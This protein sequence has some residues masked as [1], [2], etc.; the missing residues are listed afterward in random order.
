[1]SLKVYMYTRADG[2][3]NPYHRSASR[4]LEYVYNDFSI[5]LIARGLGRQDLYDQYTK[6]SGDWVNL[7]NPNVT[8][9]GFS[10]FIQPRNANGSW[11]IN[12]AFDIGGV[13]N[14]TH[15]SPV[16]GHDDCFLVRLFSLHR[17]LRRLCCIFC[18]SLPVVNSMKPVLGNIVSMFHMIWL[19]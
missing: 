19:G 11:F 3:F 2:S 6:A 10:G 13:F 17:L 16:F 9:T 1:M 14:P 4:L 5:A 18:S 12:P 15:C 7:W 8:N